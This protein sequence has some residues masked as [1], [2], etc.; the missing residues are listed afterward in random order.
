MRYSSLDY[1]TLNKT[2]LFQIDQKVDEEWPLTVIDNKKERAK[3]FLK[4]G[5]MLLFE[6]NKVPHGRQFPL[7]GDYFENLFV[8]FQ[9]KALNS[10][11][12]SCFQVSN[13]DPN[14]F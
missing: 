2:T 10:K 3:V 6:S 1:H 12:V 5:E 9:P 13:I 4:P 14:S 11:T 8:R 7:N